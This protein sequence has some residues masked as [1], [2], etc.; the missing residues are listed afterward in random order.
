MINI[1]ENRTKVRVVLTTLATYNRAETQLE[2]LTF[3]HINSLLTPYTVS[4]KNVMFVRVAQKVDV[5]SR[6]V[7]RTCY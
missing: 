5:S 4:E 2:P 7:F 1:E 6:L 3:M